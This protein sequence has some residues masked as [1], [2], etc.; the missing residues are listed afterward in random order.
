M[1]ANSY[2]FSKEIMAAEDTDGWAQASDVGFIM[3]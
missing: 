2:K 1:L 3:V